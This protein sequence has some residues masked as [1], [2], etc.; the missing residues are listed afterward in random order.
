MLL[1]A[2]VQRR[3]MRY[4]VFA[5]RPKK[6][7][8]WISRKY[9]M[10]FG[11]AF[12]I[13]L[14]VAKWSILLLSKWRFSGIF[15]QFYLLSLNCVFLA[16]LPCC[17]ECSTSCM[18]HGAKSFVFADCGS[19]KHSNPFAAV[20]FR[21]CNISSIFCRQLLTNYNYSGSAVAVQ[22]FL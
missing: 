17:R 4:S 18:Q 19:T 10:S 13:L 6:A 7:K 12:L 20:F 11:W 16:L 2:C 21:K 9:L 14:V 5:D 3:Q 15:L 8:F 22:L 1:V